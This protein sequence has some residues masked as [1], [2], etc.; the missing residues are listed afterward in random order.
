MTYIHYNA[1][2][3]CGINTLIQCQNQLYTVWVTVEKYSLLIAVWARLS[4]SSTFLS[5]RQTPAGQDQWFQK[6]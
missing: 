5:Y 2:M 3:W 6:L 1:T 4:F